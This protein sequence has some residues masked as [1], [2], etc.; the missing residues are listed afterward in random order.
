MGGTGV[1]PGVIGTRVCSGAVT[2]LAGCRVGRCPCPSAGGTVTGLSQVLSYKPT[3][4]WMSVGPG[5]VRS[6][7]GRPRPLPSGRGSRLGQQAG[8]HL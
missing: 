6:A 7:V 4:G 2:S 5:H 1:L 8:A 3:V